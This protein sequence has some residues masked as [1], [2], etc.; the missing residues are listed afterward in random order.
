MHMTLLGALLA[1]AP[2]PLYIHAETFSGLTS[3]EDQQL[4]GAIMLIVGGI[5]YLTGGL[6]LTVA[7]MR[8]STF[9]RKQEA[10]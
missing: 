8:A 2:R 5:S 4:G 7:L 3:L 6:W 9:K 10:S 1:L